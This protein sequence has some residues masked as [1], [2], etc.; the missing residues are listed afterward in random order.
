MWHGNKARARNPVI[1]LLLLFAIA[2]PLPIMSFNNFTSWLKVPANG[3]IPFHYRDPG[4]PHG[5]EN[6][7]VHQGTHKCECSSLFLG[8]IICRLLHYIQ[9]CHVR[10]GVLLLHLRSTALVARCMLSMWCVRTSDAGESHKAFV[11]SHPSMYLCRG[12]KYKNS[13]AHGV[14]DFRGGKQ[15]LAGGTIITSGQL[16]GKKHIQGP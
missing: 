16:Q 4:A 15:S 3:T 5:C 11:E 2:A 1:P 10:T 9:E 6:F 14:K 13:R 12:A 7:A 8:D